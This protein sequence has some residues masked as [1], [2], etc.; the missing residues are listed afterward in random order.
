MATIKNSLPYTF[1]IFSKRRATHIEPIGNT[2]LDTRSNAYRRTM[3]AT[4]YINILEQH[5]L[6][7]FFKFLYWNIKRKRY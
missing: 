5:D 7:D 4:Y 6:K 1:R 3:E 2:S